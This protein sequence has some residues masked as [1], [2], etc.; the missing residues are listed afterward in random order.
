GTGGAIMM[1]SMSLVVGLISLALAYYA[2]SDRFAIPFSLAIFIMGIAALTL[3]TPLLALLGRIA[4]VP[5]TPRPETMIQEIEQKKGKKM[6]RPKPSHRFGKK[7]GKVVTGKP[8]TIIVISVIVLGSL[9]AF[10]PKM[11][12]TYGLLDSFP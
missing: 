6:R 10:V 2:S 3:L 7:I 5:F 11:Q 9:A 8:W 12:F 1:S 4:F